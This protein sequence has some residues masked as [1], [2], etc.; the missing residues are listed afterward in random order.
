VS[1]YDL[2]L[3]E[4][5]L[6]EELDKNEPSVVIT[7]DPCVLRHRVAKPP[8]HVLDEACTACGQCL[9]VGCIALSM[10]GEGDERRAVIDP[11]FCVGCTVCSQVCKFDAIQA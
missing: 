7:K 1:A 4:S 6:K 3:I 5:T 2:E 9:R 10:A 11:N 8:M